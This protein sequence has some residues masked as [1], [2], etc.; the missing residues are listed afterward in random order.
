M[1]ILKKITLLGVFIV[2]IS[3]LKI[4]TARLKRGD[5]YNKL[6]QGATAFKHVAELTICKSLFFKLKNIITNVKNVF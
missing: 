4:V 6:C 5:I 3:L 2:N 1:A